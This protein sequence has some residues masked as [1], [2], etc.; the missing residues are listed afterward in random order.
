MKKSLLFFVLALISLNAIS[1]TINKNGVHDEA[2]E[3]SSNVQFIFDADSVSGF[4]EAAAWQQ[5]QSS[6]AALWEQN[7][8]VARL[9]RNYVDFKYQINSARILGG[10][11]NTV[12]AACNNVDFEAGTTAGWTVTEGLNA[13]SV[14]RRCPTASTRF[15]VVTPGFDPTIPALSRVPVGGGNFSLRL[16][17]GPTTTGHAVRAS[18]TF[19]VTPA[20]SIFIY[21]Y[22]LAVENAGHACTDQPY[23][24]I[25]FTDC[26]NNPIPC[27]DYNVV[28][29]SAS[30]VGGDPAFTT[31]TG[32]NGWSYFWKDWTT[33]SFDLSAYIGQCVKIEFVASD[34][35]QTAH[36]GWAY[37]DCSCQAMTLNLNGV[38]I[39]VGQTNNQ[40][41]SFGTNTL[42]APPGFTSY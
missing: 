27:S 31:V 19:T 28:P 6:G 41:C 30:C 15:A 25:A 24:N 10:G 26:S 23:F 42:C 16:G 5:A 32:T 39:P 12:Q 18:Q 38:D 13:N 36:G 33:K 22:A 14:R 7:I 8:F 11:G 37:V 35:V 34:C 3:K 9:K 21:K 40:L 29:S 20:N 2:S 1:Q 17:D 4:N